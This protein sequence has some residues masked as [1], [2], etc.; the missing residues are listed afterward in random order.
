MGITNE[1]IYRIGQLIQGA[2]TNYPTYVAFATGSDEF[3][4]SETSLDSE[5]IRK[6]ITWSTSGIYSKYTTEISSPEGNGSEFKSMGLV[7]EETLDAGNLWSYDLTYI[8]SKNN[9][10]NVQVEGEIIIQRAE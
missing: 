9:S 8:G 3:N 5:I 4:G 1:G 7:D 2:S 6:E 10:F